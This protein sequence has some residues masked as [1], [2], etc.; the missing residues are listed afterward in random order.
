MRQ[1][2][3]RMAMGKLNAS[4]AEHTG[5]KKIVLHFKINQR[6]RET[7]ARKT[8]PQRK[9]SIRS[10]HEAWT[11]VMP[12]LNIFA[13]FTRTFEYAARQ[14]P[15]VPAVVSSSQ[16][17]YRESCLVL[18]KSVTVPPPPPPPSP[19][20]PSPPPQFYYKIQC[21]FY[22]RHLNFNYERL[23]R[24]FGCDLRLDV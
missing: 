1:H 9:H 18:T 22:E 17:P 21:A 5:E 20:S 4:R 24:I 3:H 2:I 13:A 16:Q 10:M 12:N 23:F 19:S 11:G 15:S 8:T 6:T 14:T 7:L